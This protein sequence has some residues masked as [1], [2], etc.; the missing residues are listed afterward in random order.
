[1]RLGKKI[2][3]LISSFVLVTSA[4]K[5]SNAGFLTFLGCA[6]GFFTVLHLSDLLGSLFDKN[7]KVKIHLRNTIST[8]AFSV[9]MFGLDYS[10][11][12]YHEKRDHK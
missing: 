9:G 11:D 1:M 8:L 7:E 2:L 3:S 6:G 12:K 5:T 10:L 4:V